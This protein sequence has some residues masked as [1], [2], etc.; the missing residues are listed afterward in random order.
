MCSAS[1]E[2]GS[3]GERSRELADGKES[4]VGAEEMRIECRVRFLVKMSVTH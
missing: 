4:A 1:P 2:K 3:N